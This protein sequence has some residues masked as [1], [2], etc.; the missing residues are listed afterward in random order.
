MAVPE[1]LLAIKPKFR[2]WLHLVALPTAAIVGISLVILAPDTKARV[3]AAIYAVCVCIAFGASALLHRGNWSEGVRAVLRRLD[4]G[5]IFLLIAGSYT[6]FAALMIDD[7]RGRLLLWL[8][9]IGA[10]AGIM[11]RVFWLRAPRWLYTPVYVVLGWVAVAFLPSILAS[12]GAGVVTLIV[13]GGLMYSIGAVVYATKWPNPA[14]RWFGFHEVFHALTLGGW[15]SQAVAVF[16][17]TLSV[18]AA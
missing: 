15:I 5:A 13:I 18:R 10:L 11:F 8:V 1:A 7:S 12:Y 17:V 14:P 2:G 16:V 4:H 6:P 9:W 3:A